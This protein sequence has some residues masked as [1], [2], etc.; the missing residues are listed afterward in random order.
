LG[1]ALSGCTHARWHSLS[2]DPDYA[3]PHPVRLYVAVSDSVADADEHGSVLTL[4]E[5][6][7]A[8]L[9]EAG[10]RVKLV[11][12]RDDENPPLPRVELQF[13]E[14][15]QGARALRNAGRYVPLVGTGVAALGP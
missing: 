6:V 11:L 13:V 7:E 5:T 9:A 12:A 10:I 14:L 1:S 3:L 2:K 8:D 15:D 4:V